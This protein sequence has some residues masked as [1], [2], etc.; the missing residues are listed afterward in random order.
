M[1]SR[2]LVVGAAAL[3]LFGSGLVMAAG[4]GAPTGT[5]AKTFVKD[6]T[7]TTKIKTK[8]AA[9]SPASLAKIHV[10]TDQAGVVY[11]S[12][13]AKSQADADQAVQI[14]KATEDVVSVKNEIIV[15][16]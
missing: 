11:L 2:A 8:L 12:G 5:T 7:I 14:A 3:A 6:S 15:K 10:D 16:P 13:T 4:E 9:E 1:K